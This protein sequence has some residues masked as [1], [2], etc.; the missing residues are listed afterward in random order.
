MLARSNLT[1]VGSLGI[2]YASQGGLPEGSPAF[3]S[4]ILLAPLH[5][6]VPRFLWAGKPLQNIGLWYTHEVLGFR[7]ES[8]TAMSP[9]TYLN[10][11]GGP[12][13][14]VIG[15]FFVGVCQRALFEGFRGYGAGGLIVIV[16][17]LGTL[18]SIDS[19]F[20]TF[21]IGIMRMLPMLVIAQYLI[22]QRRVTRV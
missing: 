18:A 1:Y 7:F 16:G 9:F 17:L 15:F 8:S 19:A 11:A 12:V 4:D 22:L 6:I 14:V 21:I 13:A 3:R 20:N 10:F 5:A 2:E